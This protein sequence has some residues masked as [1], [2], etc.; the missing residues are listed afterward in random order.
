M[1]S[2]SASGVFTE[3]ALAQC[4]DWSALAQQQALADDVLRHLNALELRDTHLRSVA[5]GPEPEVLAKAS[6]ATMLDVFTSLERYPRPECTPAVVLVRAA[7]DA[8][9]SRD[10]HQALAQVRLLLVHLNV[11][12]LTFALGCSSGIKQRW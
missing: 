3:G 4:V 10:S 1:S 7:H 12:E 6:L 8:Y 2:L 11:S 5:D 9:I